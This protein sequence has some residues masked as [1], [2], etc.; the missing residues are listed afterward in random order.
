MLQDQ[1]EIVVAY[2]Q[3]QEHEMLLQYQIQ[4]ASVH[5]DEEETW[6]YASPAYHDVDPEIYQTH[7][8]EPYLAWVQVLSPSDRTYS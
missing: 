5:W 3:A 6:E 8:Y 2:E 1:L 4:L 7:V